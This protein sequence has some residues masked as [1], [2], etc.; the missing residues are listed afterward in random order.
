MIFNKI[1]KIEYKI[2]QMEIKMKQMEIKMIKM[3]YKMKQMEYKMKQMENN[4]EYLSE[5]HWEALEIISNNYK[6]GLYT[7]SKY[8][9]SLEILYKV[10]FPPVN[11]PTS[12]NFIESMGI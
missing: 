9:S 11:H 6:N 12:N 2:N 10:F 8:I 4:E 7:Q 1:K 5:E 3:E